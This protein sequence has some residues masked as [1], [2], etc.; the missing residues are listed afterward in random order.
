MFLKSN[1]SATL[2]IIGL[3]KTLRRAERHRV[4][5]GHG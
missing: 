4:G 2:Q 3:A 1:T 5:A